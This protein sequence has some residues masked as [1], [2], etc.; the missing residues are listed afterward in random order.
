[1]KKRDRRNATL[2]LSIKFPRTFAATIKEK[3][4]SFCKVSIGGMTERTKCKENIP[5]VFEVSKNKQGAMEIEV[6]PNNPVPAGEHIAVVMKIFNPRSRGMHIVN[7]I[8]QTPG[9]LPISSYIGSWS[10]DIE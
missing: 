10:L 7:G 3:N 2:K 6:F 9:D 1:M 4:L 8:S 5:S